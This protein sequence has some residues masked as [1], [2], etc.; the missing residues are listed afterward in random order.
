MVADQGTLPLAQAIA[1]QGHNPD[2][3]L[4]EIT[5]MKAMIEASGPILDSGS[6]HVTRTGVMQAEPSE[7]WDVGWRSGPDAQKD[8]QGSIDT[9]HVLI[10]EGS[11]LTA[12]PIPRNRDDF[13]RH[14]LRHDPQSI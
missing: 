1:R 13:V 2:A 14:D 8:D 10:G 3:V 11:D 12:E 4:A 7:T 5:A 9:E 6:R